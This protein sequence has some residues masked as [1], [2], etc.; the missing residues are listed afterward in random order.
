MLFARITVYFSPGRRE[1]PRAFGRSS[2]KSFLLKNIT[3]ANEN[4]ANHMPVCDQVTEQMA[5]EQLQIF[6]HLPLTHFSWASG[7]A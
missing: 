3:L 2:G 5:A 6:L 7:L 1:F 4:L